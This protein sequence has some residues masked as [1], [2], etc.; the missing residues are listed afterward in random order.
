MKLDESLSKEIPH[1]IESTDEK[2]YSALEDVADRHLRTSF[3]GEPSEKKVL[4]HACCR[5]KVDGRLFAHSLRSPGD[6]RNILQFCHELQK[7]SRKRQTISLDV[8]REYAALKESS[9]V[10]VIEDQL[11]KLRKCGMKKGCDQDFY[12]LPSDLTTVLSKDIITSIVTSSSPPNLTPMEMSNYIEKAN[13]N[14]KVLAI[15]IRAGL[16]MEIL[17]HFLDC[18]VIDSEL[19]LKDPEVCCKDHDSKMDKFKKNQHEFTAPYLKRNSHTNFTGG[20]ILPIQFVPKNN[21]WDRPGIEKMW[22]SGELYCGGKQ[23]DEDAFRKCVEDASVGKGASG[24]VYRAKVDPQLHELTKVCLE[25][26]SLKLI[27]LRTLQNREALFALK[28][29]KKGNRITFRQEVQVL[30]KLR[31]RRHDHIVTHYAD[32]TQDD[33][34]YMLLPLAECNLRE[35]WDRSEF[36]VGKHLPWFLK[37][38]LGL[39]GAVE[40]IHDIGGDALTVDLQGQMMG[41]HH[42]LKPDNILYFNGILKIADF[43]SSKVEISPDGKSIITHSPSGTPTY[44]SPEYAIAGRT[45]RPFDLWSLGCT[46]L[47]HL[48]WVSFGSKGVKDFTE[49]RKGYRTPNGLKDSGFWVCTERQPR[50]RQPVIDHTDILRKYLSHPLQE[51]LWVIEKRMLDTNPD[52]RIKA[53]DLFKQLDRIYNGELATL[54]D[55]D[56]NESPSLK[57]S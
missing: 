8:L 43:G 45:S 34:H 3:S 48:T 55:T 19:P 32:W 13:A 26:D 33:T 10:D 50:L 39:T 16:P 9:S 57:P 17:K 22:P 41:W 2:N 54:T 20:R 47:E 24:N 4:R 40:S 49:K 23:R 56:E 51:V 25:V 46:F 27:K 44:E 37:Q 14:P 1:V 36:D 28:V 5:V 11:H 7:K 35:F 52:T 15:F 31:S 30:S 12:V 38:L 42:D 53:S 21:M 18:G 29:F 6:L